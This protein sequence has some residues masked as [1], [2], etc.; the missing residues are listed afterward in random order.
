MT[1]VV[2]D[3]SSLISIS[4]TCLINVLPRLSKKAGI[5]FVIPSKVEQ[6]TVSRPLS[7]KQFELN[8]LRIQHALE[9]GWLKVEKLEK[10]GR[11]TSDDF[12]QWSNNLFYTDFG[13]LTL[14]QAGEAETI[15]LLKES[16]AKF[17]GV[18]E[19]NTRMLVEDIEGLRDYLRKKYGKIKMNLDNAENLKEL[20]EGIS[21]VRSSEFI[22]MGFQNNVFEP[23]IA[24]SKQ[25]LEASLYAVKYSG[26]AVSEQEIRDFLKEQQ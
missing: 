24:N 12:L 19:R 16:K 23:D 18:D 17:L 9:Q 1:L 6:E 14:I 5:E 25:G 13:A 11:K 26:C 20:L 4:K 2:L 7:I 8:A 3:S 22:A 10:E 15:G 21:V